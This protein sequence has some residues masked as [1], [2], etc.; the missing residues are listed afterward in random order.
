MLGI[1]KKDKLHFV[2]SGYNAEEC[3]PTVLA[4]RHTFYVPAGS[5]LLLSCVVQHCGEVWTGDWIRKNPSEVIKP[6][7]RHH[8]SNFALSADQTRLILK[9]LN[10]NQSDE[11]FYG[12]SI[13]WSQG[14]SDQGHVS[15]VNVT[16]GKMS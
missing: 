14:I 9:F 11:G 3:S 16:S 1:D 2:H 15:Y 4:R 12:C 10:V 7:P 13:T 5:S 8:L 6:T